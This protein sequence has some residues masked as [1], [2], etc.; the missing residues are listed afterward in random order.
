M[1][2]TVPSFR[3]RIGLPRTPRSCSY[4]SLRFAIPTADQ[5]PPDFAVLSLCSNNQRNPLLCAD[6][7]A[8]ASQLLAAVQS[9]PDL[10]VPFGS[11][12][13]SGSAVPTDSALEQLACTLAGT[14]DALLA[15]A[16]PPVAAAL[17]GIADRGLRR[18]SDDGSAASISET[19]AKVRTTSCKEN[20]SGLFLKLMRRSFRRSLR[21]SL[22]VTR[23]S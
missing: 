23:A 15:G 16:P 9:L 14:S 10:A 21:F 7:A 22:L 17:F 11:A 2:L 6:T 18:F 12:V 3:P 5:S 1:L 4:R 20:E 19:A 13:P 8:W